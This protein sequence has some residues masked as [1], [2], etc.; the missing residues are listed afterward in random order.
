MS[1]DAGGD[2]P[3]IDELRRAVGVSGDAGGDS[4]VLDELRRAVGVSGDAP[5]GA[6]L[7]GGA[8]LRLGGV[9][10]ATLLGGRPLISYPLAAL[11][12]VV[13]PVAVVAKRDSPLPV[14]GYGVEIWHEPDEPRHPLAGIV[15]AL[16][17]AAGRS[18]VVLACDM[19]FVTP[20][21]V[22][23]LCAPLAP[24]TVAVV[25]SSDGRLQ[26]LCARYEADAADA[27]ERALTDDGR[28][29]LSEVVAALN[30]AVAGFPAALL[31]NVNA[32]EDLARAEADLRAG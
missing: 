14:L 8:G 19:P 24:G 1:A 27:L 11:R 29:R 20:E 22:R 4:P 16:R 12:A 23:A 21:V 6:V 17:R 30:P 26:P 5:V 9:K 3:A 13:S 2:S 10:P 7:A 32:P 28:A 18:V 25:T 15:E 31:V